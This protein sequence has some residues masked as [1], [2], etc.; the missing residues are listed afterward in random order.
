MIVHCHQ[1]VAANACAHAHRR[2]PLPRECARSESRTPN[3]Q[4]FG[5]TPSGAGARGPSA[6]RQAARAAPGECSRSV[7]TGQRGFRSSSPFRSHCNSTSPRSSVRWSE[8]NS[9]V[10]GA[11]RSVPRH[12]RSSRGPQQR[13]P[14]R[15]A[16]LPSTSQPWVPHHSWSETRTPR[17]P[18]PTSGGA[19]TGSS[20]TRR[21]GA[22]RQ[23]S[24]SI[25]EIQADLAATPHQ[26]MCSRRYL[27]ART[28]GVRDGVRIIA[29]S[30]RSMVSAARAAAWGERPNRLWVADFTYV[31][32]WRGL[33]YV[34]IVGRV[35][36]T[37]CRLAGAYAHAEG[38]GAGCPRAGAP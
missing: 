10:S 22:R 31:A 26:K 8:P 33:V 21:G 11:P 7:S 4:G 38:S 15:F 36:A 17:L 20:T 24:V 1:G 16:S 35:L 30:T 5:A 29:R 32:T 19:S 2:R 37:Y 18:P 9:P 13:C 23:A 25:G 34:A 6:L 28:I 3:R 14:G 27:S 12:P